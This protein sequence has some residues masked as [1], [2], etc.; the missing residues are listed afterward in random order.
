M[1]KKLEVIHVL[2]GQLKIIFSQMEEKEYEDI[3]E[4]R[5]RVG[6]PLLIRKNRK[7]FFID[8][9]GSVVTEASLAYRPVFADIQGTVALLSHYS[10]Y[11]FE[12]EVRQGFLTIE[13]GHRIGFVGK[14]VL[15][16]GYIKTIKDINSLNFRISHEY[17]N[18]ADNI[19][20]YVVTQEGVQ[21]CLLISPPGCGKTTL[22][23]DMIRQLSYGKEGVFDGYTIGVVDERGEIAGCYQGQIQ[24]DLG[25]RTD[26]LSC[27]P[28]AEG[29]LMLLRSMAPQVIAIDEIGKEEDVRAVE[30]ILNA[31]VTLLCTV[32]GNSVEEIQRHPILGNLLRK[33]IFG[34]VIVLSGKEKTGRIQA[35]YNR[36]LDKIYCPKG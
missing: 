16:H 23:R 11:A 18:C 15:E 8:E 1:K 22:L 21:H 10:F 17:T 19:M 27:C 25:S 33:Q 34:A 32:H 7:D 4:I 35:V 29:M 26:V 9:K 36:A 20:K 3:E 30:S 6:Q 5:I 28:K 12:E 31:G 14:A 24:N 13:G 2:G